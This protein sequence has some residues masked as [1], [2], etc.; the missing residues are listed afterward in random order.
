MSGQVAMVAAGTKGIGLATAMKL[1]E[2]GHRVSICGRTASTLE[3]ALTLLGPTANGC[4][5]DV[6]SA[7]DLVKWHR[8]V[9]TELGHPSI[10]VTN[11]GGPP[12]GRVDAVSDEEWQRGFETVILM[13]TRL[14]RLTVPAMREAKWGRIVHI[15]SLVAKEPNPILTISSTLRAG[16]MALALL[17]AREWAADGVTVNSVLPGHTLTDRQLHLAEVRAEREGS[18]IEQVLQSQAKEIPVQRL[19]K[20][21][22]IAAAVA[23]LCSKDAAFISGQSLLVDGGNVRGIG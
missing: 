10:V 23:F 16:M 20:P 17:Q 14:C 3:S 5:A 1:T 7:D 21:E 19:G 11:T 4:V 6:N 18:T 2:L 13:A 9:E 22:E 12:V 15:T 8:K